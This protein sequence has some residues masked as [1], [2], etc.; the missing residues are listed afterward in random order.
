VTQKHN[1][2]SGKQQTHVC[3]F[4]KMD[5]VNMIPWLVWA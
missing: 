4:V 1:K 2:S 5:M 3:N